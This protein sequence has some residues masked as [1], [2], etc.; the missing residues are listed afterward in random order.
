MSKRLIESK[1]IRTIVM[2]GSVN[3]ATT[4]SEDIV[5][6][7]HV[8]QDDVTV[9][10]YDLAVIPIITDTM[11]NADGQLHGRG[12]LS[13]QGQRSQPGSLGMLQLHL[14][15]NAAIVIGGKNPVQMTRMFPEG[16][17]VEID[18]GEGLNI[19]TLVEWTGGATL[20]WWVDATIYYVE[21]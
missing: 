4:V 20:A 3:V 17:G 14:V 16:Y 19:L 6:A 1:R 13:R 18:E 7:S 10:G 5:L 21:R 12:E 11:S 15:W 9:I 8:F 2:G